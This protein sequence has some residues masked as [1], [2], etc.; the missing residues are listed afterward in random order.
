M[1]VGVMS[2]TSMDAVDIA[3]VDLDGPAPRLIATSSANWPAPL[4]ERLQRCAANHPLSATGFATLDADVGAFIGS[5]IN[6]LIDRQSIAK[7]RIRAIGC[8]GQTVAH[9]PGDSPAVTLQ[10]GDANVIAERTGIATVSDFRRRDMAAGGQGAPLA[11]A[12]HA[13]ML[14]ADSEFR[15]I[16][17]LGGIANITLLPATTEDRVIGLD[18]GPANCLMDYWISRHLGTSFDD[19]GAWAAS[20][21]TSQPLLRAMLADDY[22]AMAAPKS[23]GTQYF[24]P[25]WLG[26]N[27]EGFADLR[28]VDV[29]AT[30]LAL[31][32]DSVA[33]AIR[34]HGPDA[35]RVLVCGGGVHN[36]ALMQR[37]ASTLGLPV[38]STLDYGIDPDW[39][40]AIAFAWLAERALSNA[41]GN[42]PDVTGA[43]GERILGAIHPA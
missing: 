20:G 2:G 10:I 38:E 39:M 5:A 22:F 7:A 34:R 8:H 18:T 40:E 6:T 27:L 42:L 4:L 43:R 37:L 29:Q 30:L 21:T 28:P 36:V 17:N 9:A 24:S 32:S 16:L 31:T 14:R 13:A 1:F 15:A 19:K 12:F 41:P 23:T 3:V 26:R 11:P 33:A 25:E 35:D